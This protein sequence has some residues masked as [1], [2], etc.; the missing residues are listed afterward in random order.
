MACRALRIQPQQRN[1][2]V[3]VIKDMRLNCDSARVSFSGLAL[4]WIF[5]LANAVILAFPLQ[6]LAHGNVVFHRVQL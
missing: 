3:T 6:I 1:I 2:T 4:D 5:I